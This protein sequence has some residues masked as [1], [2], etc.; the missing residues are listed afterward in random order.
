MKEVEDPVYAGSVTR[1][2]GDDLAS[3]MMPFK[4]RGESQTGRLFME[5]AKGGRMVGFGFNNLVVDA[6]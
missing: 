4:V 5:G 6:R 1:G 2:W 3:G